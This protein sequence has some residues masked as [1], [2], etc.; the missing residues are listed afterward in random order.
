MIVM[1]QRIE[2]ASFDFYFNKKKSI[3]F[4][5]EI[6]ISSNN[7]PNE[8]DEYPTIEADLNALDV[9]SMQKSLSPNN[10]ISGT[11]PKQ[12]GCS[13]FCYNQGICVLVGQKI[14]CRCA[15][16]FI[17]VRCQIARKI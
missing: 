6:T 10:G 5:I 7:N 17:G 12:F 3:L 9:L 11:T 4:N 15:P 16:G 8:I 14:T 1:I 13:S 2:L